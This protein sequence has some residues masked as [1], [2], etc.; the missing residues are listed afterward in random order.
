MAY[1]I[2]MPDGNLVMTLEISLF[3]AEKPALELIK[4]NVPHHSGRT[5]SGDTKLWTIKAE[6]A[7]EIQRAFA[8]V[9]AWVAWLTSAGMHVFISKSTGIAILPFENDEDN[10]YPGTHHTALKMVADGNKG[11]Y[12]AREIMASTNLIDVLTDA[13]TPPVDGQLALDL[14]RATGTK[15][16]RPPKPKPPIEET[17]ELQIAYV[18]RRKAGR[19][20]VFNREF[21]YRFSL[22][23]SPDNFCGKFTDEQ[24]RAW[25]EMAELEAFQKIGIPDSINASTHFTALGLEPHPNLKHETI[26]KAFAT[27]SLIY[28]PDHNHARNAAAMFAPVL[29]AWQFFNAARNDASGKTM[30]RY[31]AAVSIRESQ[32]AD[33]LMINPEVDVHLTAHYLYA[34][35]MCGILH[36]AWTRD[37]QTGEII[38][39]RI[40]KIT[41]LVDSLGRIWLPTLH[42]NEYQV[43]TVIGE[44]LTPEEYATRDLVD[45]RTDDDPYTNSYT[46]NFYAA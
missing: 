9:G 21:T 46:N 32:H 14:A 13:G 17:G 11:D 40:E 30:R 25:A 3:D 20:Y 34:N 29:Y 39:K 4:A 38:V 2:E 42:G 45:N 26:R 37:T 22:I 33:P 6:Y 28:H 15:A 27:Q 24:L 18:N 12:I 31:L 19:N 41:P 10:L 36:G 35:V 44:W 23:Q 1:V 16:P 7:S 5:F 8:D 43:Q